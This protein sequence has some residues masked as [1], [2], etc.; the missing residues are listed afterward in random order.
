ME[1]FLK[2][3]KILDTNVILYDPNV[4]FN[5]PKEL[6]IVPISVLEELDKF[7]K[8]ADELGRNARQVSRK[9]D[10]LTK[11]SQLGVISNSQN[12]NAIGVELNNGGRILIELNHTDSLSQL[13]NKIIDNRILAT[14]H[15][16]FNKFK[17]SEVKLLT[18]DSN[19]RIKANAFG[20]RS[21]DYEADRELNIDYKYLGYR[22]I[23]VSSS[24]FKNLSSEKYIQLKEKFY[25]NE[26]ACIIEKDTNLSLVTKYNSKNERFELLNLPNNTFGIGPK[27]L[28]QQIALDLLLDPD[29]P[30]VTITGKAGTGKTLLAVAAGLEMTL[31][32]NNYL[33]MLIARPIVPMGKNIGYLPGTIEEK[34]NPWMQPIFDNLE[35][36]FNSGES[37]KGAINDKYKILIDQGVIQ[38]EPLTYIRG[39]SIPNQFM[40]IDEAQNLSKHELK[41]ILSRVGK[42]TKIILTG[43]PDQIDNPFIDKV[44]CGLSQVVEK[45]KDSG[46]TGHINLQK[47]ERSALAEAVV[48]LLK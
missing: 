35:F 29:I 39:R 30:L 18:K 43:D 8:N 10:K 16:Y 33:R 45:F 6:V 15:Y 5:F 4:I 25:P 9:I 37:R 13:D 40:I 31:E 47:G 28:E 27:N 11:K 12:E 2:K 36:L 34:L 48:E 20:V 19:L 3:I 42:G 26:Y 32:N 17:D 22:I 46:L 7:K 41:T 21:E 14:A 44:S 23:Q 1:D 38:V 24:V